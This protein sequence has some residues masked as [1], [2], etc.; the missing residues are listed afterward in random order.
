M[1]EYIKGTVEYISEGYV[2]IENHG[3]G[4]KINTSSFTIA[5][6]NGME[7]EVIVYTQMIVR[8]DDISLCGFSSRHE[9]TLFRMLTSVSGIGTKVALA[10]LSSIGVYDLASVIASGDVNTLV[11]APGVGKKTAQRVIL[12]LKD[13]VDKQLSSVALSVGSINAPAPVSVTSNQREALEALISLGY[14]SD[15]AEQVIGRIDTTDKDTEGIIKEAL[16]LIMAG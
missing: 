9:L 4:F 11:K 8:E 1:Y 13:K 2:V 12:E 16:S 5:D 15:E 7:D 6:L 3:M 14:S 10:V